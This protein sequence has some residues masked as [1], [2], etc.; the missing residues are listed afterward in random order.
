MT[1]PPYARASEGCR[2]F[3]WPYIES[4]AI[5]RIKATYSLDV[6]TVEALDRLAS[7]W[8]TSKSEVLRRLIRER[9]TV[10]GYA[11]VATA[12]SGAK[13]KLAALDQLQKSMALTPAAAAAW[14]R[15]NRAMRRASSRHRG[16]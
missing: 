16:L 7:A 2:L 11:P 4:M 5:P 15:E 9:A 13:A 8:E 10:P 6:E 1:A 12:M 3:V 14:K